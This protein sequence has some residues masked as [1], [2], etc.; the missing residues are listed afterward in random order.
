M[1]SKVRCHRSV[2]GAVACFATR[3]SI[4]VLVHFPNFCVIF[5]GTIAGG[6]PAANDSGEATTTAANDNEKGAFKKPRRH[7]SRPL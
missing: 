6:A 1:T 4:V 2:C 3:R 7:N 5:V